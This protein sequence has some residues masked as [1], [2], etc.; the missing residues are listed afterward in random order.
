MCKAWSGE[1]VVISHTFMV[2]IFKCTLCT[3]YYFDYC[4]P[5]LFVCL[6]V[7]LWIHWYSSGIIFSAVTNISST[8]TTV[9]PETTSA[10]NVV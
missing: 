8:N 9:T 7:C 10:G 6:F 1:V 2:N 4:M 3:Q 5:Y